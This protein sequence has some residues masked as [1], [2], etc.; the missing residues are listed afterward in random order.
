MTKFAAVVQAISLSNSKGRVYNNT[1]GNLFGIL[2]NTPA[3]PLTK[4]SILI[5]GG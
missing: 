1:H 4:A 5:R 2:R 3:P